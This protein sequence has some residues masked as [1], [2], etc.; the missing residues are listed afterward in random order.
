MQGVFYLG[1]LFIDMYL[2]FCL[3]SAPYIF[4]SLMD[5]FTW[6]FIK[7]H[8]LVNLDQYVDDFIYAVLRTTS[9]DPFPSGSPLFQRVEVHRADA[10]LRIH[11]VLVDAP[12][13]TISLPQD[14]P[15]RYSHKRNRCSPTPCRSFKCSLMQIFCD[16]LISFALSR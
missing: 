4:T 1:W 8:R 3:R 14:K 9:G 10:D 16:R 11:G 6:I 2:A 13:M 7:T 12:S 15:D 5:L